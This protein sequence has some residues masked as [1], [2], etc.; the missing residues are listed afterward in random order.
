MP[1]NKNIKKF[2][3]DFWEKSELLVANLISNIQEIRNLNKYID[4]TAR[5]TS[6][7]KN[8]YE[9]FGSLIKKFRHAGV[10]IT[11]LKT[12]SLTL[13]IFPI[14]CIIRK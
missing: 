6:E 13:V 9:H 10:N 7:Q 8:R 14:H 2:Y 4:K 5:L 1:I 12:E 3:L 11:P